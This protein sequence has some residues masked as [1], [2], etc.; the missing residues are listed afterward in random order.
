MMRFASLLALVFSLSFSLS[1]SLPRSQCFA[2]FFRLILSS[3]F[4]IYIEIFIYIFLECALVQV[5]EVVYLLLLRQLSF[6]LNLMLSLLSICVCFGG[7]CCLD[8][9]SSLIYFLIWLLQ[10]SFK[11]RNL[12][13][14]LMMRS[15]CWPFMNT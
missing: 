1:P 14:S 13:Q 5:T 10:F 9:F 11:I 4:Y 6:S 12:L 7:N 3:C 15:L 8:S 2:L